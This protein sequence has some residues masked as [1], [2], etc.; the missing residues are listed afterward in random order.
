M[1]KGKENTM[2]SAYA[3]CAQLSMVIFMMSQ[4]GVGYAEEENTQVQKTISSGYRKTSFGL[5]KKKRRTLTM[6]KNKDQCF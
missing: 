5:K 3:A 6:T 2:I 1:V 4:E